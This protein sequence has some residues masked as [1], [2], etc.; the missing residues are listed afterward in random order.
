[1][2]NNAG[3]IAFL[4]ALYMTVSPQIEI[5]Y[6][7]RRAGKLQLAVPEKLVFH[8]RGFHHLDLAH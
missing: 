2:T 5:T 1:M 8:A 6:G 3:E 4:S 7:P